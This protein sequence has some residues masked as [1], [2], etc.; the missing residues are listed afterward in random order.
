VS[1]PF[2]G[3]FLPSMFNRTATKNFENVFVKMMDERRKSGQKQ[4][5][6]VDLCIE[7]ID[8]LGSPEN[9]SLGISEQT[10]ICHAFIFFFAGQDQIS[11]VSATMIYHLLQNP[12]IERRVYE[13]VDLFYEKYKGQVE[14]E[15]LSELQYLAGCINEALRLVPFFPRVERVCT[16]DWKS[17]EFNLEIKKGM[18]TM[19]PLWAV[20]RNPK[21]FPDPEQF[22]PE[23]FLPEN[24]SKLHPYA[25]S[26][27]GHGPRNCIGSK[28]SYEVL[29]MFNLMLLKTFKFHL[30]ADSK[31]IYV[32]AGNLVAAHAPF[33][34]DVSL[35]Q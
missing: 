8:R 34:F 29:Q 17:E 21:Y 15:N 30:R 20:H 27:F 4:K 5:D 24:K 13:E 16:K 22:N 31:P 32:P 35:R 12:D 6:V 11:T 10:V 2:L 9:R 23:R 18:T 25:F 14:H 3:K 26:A 28:F 1:F 7:W 19:I 33:Y